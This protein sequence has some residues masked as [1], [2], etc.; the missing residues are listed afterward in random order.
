M[1]SIVLLIIRALLGGM[2]QPGENSTMID[3]VKELCRVLSAETVTVDDVVAVSG[4][5]PTEN[6]IRSTIVQP[7][8]SSFSR[9]VIK[10]KSDVPATVA[11]TLAEDLTLG[12]LRE[13]FGDY[14]NVP[15]VHPEDS[16]R[17]AFS[18][19]T[20]DAFTCTIFAH[21]DPLKQATDTTLVDSLLI[22]RDRRL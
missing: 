20:G 10:T 18:V 15:R 2:V 9:V 19:D 17:A 16:A 12:S 14:R 22:R 1:C 5:T 3:T 7:E 8:S 13:E 6:G 11:L 4:N 21:F